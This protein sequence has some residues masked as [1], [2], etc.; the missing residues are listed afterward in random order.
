MALAREGKARNFTLGPLVGYLLGR[1]A[2]ARALRLLF[3]G[4]LPAEDWQPELY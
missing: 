2:E 1:E 4:R 3:S